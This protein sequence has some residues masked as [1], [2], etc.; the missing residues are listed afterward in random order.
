MNETDYPRHVET[1]EIYYYLGESR[2]LKG[3]ANIRF[4][5]LVPD[6]HPG[7]PKFK[8]KFDSFYRKTKRWCKSENWHEWVKR[9]EIEER[10]KRE[11]EVASR[12]AHLADALANYQELVREGLALFAEKARLPALLKQAIARGDESAEAQIRERIKNG[13]GIEIK[14]FREAKEMVELDIHL[15]SIMDRQPFPELKGKYENPLPEEM[16]EKV[17]R[18]MEFFRKKAAESEDNQTMVK[19]F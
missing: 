17:D 7:V 12:T 10:Q 15:A 3:A 5:Q 1:F 4:R 9:K 6:Y 19:N 11:N 13:E 14:N 18:I 8:R 2:T 16:R